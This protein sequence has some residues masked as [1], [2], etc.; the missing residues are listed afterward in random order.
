MRT[1]EGISG[2]SLFPIL[3]PLCGPGPKIWKG[4][5]HAVKIMIHY[6]YQF[7]GVIRILCNLRRKTH[8][9][10]AFLFLWRETEISF[11]TKILAADW[12]T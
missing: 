4:G 5:V 6:Q 7:L 9:I 8:S 2:I 11:I 3:T 1:K 12:V 10:R